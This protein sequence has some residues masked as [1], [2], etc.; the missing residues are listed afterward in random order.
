MNCQGEI[1]NRQNSGPSIIQ[2]GKTEPMAEKKLMRKK[3]SQIEAQS[4]ELM[5][6]EMTRYPS[7]SNVEVFKPKKYVD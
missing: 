5:I 1:L 7:P 6:V 3:S 2:G 4:F